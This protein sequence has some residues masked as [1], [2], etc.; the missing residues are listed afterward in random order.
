[1]LVNWAAPLSLS[2][3]AP[4]GTRSFVFVITNFYFSLSGIH[5]S[6]GFG[7]VAHFCS[8]PSLAARARAAGPGRSTATGVRLRNLSQA[9]EKRHGEEMRTMRRCVAALFALWWPLS[10]AGILFMLNTCR[11]GR[12]GIFITSTSAWLNQ[13]LK[14]AKSFESQ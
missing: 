3:R 11:W 13:F 9:A 4:S 1:M 5:P 8:L 6:L 10:S 14:W 2:A 12:K 7:Y